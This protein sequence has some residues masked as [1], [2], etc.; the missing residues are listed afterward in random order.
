[1]TR[2]AIDHQIDDVNQLKTFSL[3]RYAFDESL[4]T[5]YEWVFT[6]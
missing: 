2:F 1:M 6:R 5:E 4:S 3:D